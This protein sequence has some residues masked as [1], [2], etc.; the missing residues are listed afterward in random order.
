MNYTDRLYDPR[1]GDIFGLVPDKIA[2][3][4]KVALKEMTGEGIPV[5]IVW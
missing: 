5:N 2:V 3:M 4:D 1:T